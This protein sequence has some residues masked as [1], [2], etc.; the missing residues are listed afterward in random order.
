[1]TRRPTSLT[2]GYRN[3]T[4]DASVIF[5]QGRIF[6]FWKFG[7]AVLRPFLGAAATPGRGSGVAY[8]A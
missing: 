5:A 4:R 7:S 3:P 2:V 8:P 6:S 1:M